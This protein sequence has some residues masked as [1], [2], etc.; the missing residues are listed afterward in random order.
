[1]TE[2]LQGK[3][4][5]WCIAAESAAKTYLKNKDFYIYYSK[6]KHGKPTIPRAGIETEGEKIS[7][8]RGIAKEQN[9]DPYI[10]DV[11]EKKLD[12]FPDKE[13][14][15]KKTADM[16]LLT[17]IDNKQKKE[18][19]LTRDELSL[20]MRLMLKLKDSDCET[21]RELKKLKKGETTVRIL[22]I[23]LNAG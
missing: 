15:K 18:E 22:L 5:G 11:I 14:Y 10:V 6:D 21:T 8:I 4:T 3:G 23:Y 20:F 17:Q 13:K 16:K 9:L 12:E 19:K 7:T 2:S 1:M